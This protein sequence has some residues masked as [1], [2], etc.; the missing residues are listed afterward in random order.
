MKHNTREEAQEEADR[1]NRGS[2]YN[3]YYVVAVEGGYKVVAKY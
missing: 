2:D 1:I 3:F